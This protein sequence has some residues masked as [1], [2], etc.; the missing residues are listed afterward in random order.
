MIS[1]ERKRRR[2]RRRIDRKVKFFT[3][4]SGAISPFYPMSVC[5]ERSRK[6][7][8]KKKEEEEKSEPSMTN[9]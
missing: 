6:D 1:K 8:N 3:T 5:P 4:R 9:F 7:F 2:R